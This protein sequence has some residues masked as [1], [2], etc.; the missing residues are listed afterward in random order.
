DKAGRQSRE[1]DRDSASRRVN[2]ISG[3]PRS[4]ARPGSD[5]P[6]TL[7]LSV[8]TVEILNSIAPLRKWHRSSL[9]KDYACAPVALFANVIGLSH[10]EPFTRF[11]ETALAPPTADSV[12]P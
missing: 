7:W 4:L 12:K 9:L 8:R 10:V 3:R 1:I 2:S 5:A 11:K 6:R